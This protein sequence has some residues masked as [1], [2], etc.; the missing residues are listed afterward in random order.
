MKNFGSNCRENVIFFRRPP[1]LMPDFSGPHNPEWSVEHIGA[2]KALTRVMHQ[3]RR[4]AL[5]WIWEP[6]NRLT[7]MRNYI[8]P[9]MVILIYHNTFWIGTLNRLTLRLFLKERINSTLDGCTLWNFSEF[10]ALEWCFINKKL[11]YS[12]QQ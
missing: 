1:P 4:R 10:L 5:I 11:I 6:Y 9:Y 12:Q 3:R 8:T 2:L 7:E